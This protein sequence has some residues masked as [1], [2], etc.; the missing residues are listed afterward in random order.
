[1]PENVTVYSGEMARLTCKVTQSGQSGLYWLITEERLLPSNLPDFYQAS[2]YIWSPEGFDD[3]YTTSIALEM[4]GI[5]ET[6]NTSVECIG[7]YS[8]AGYILSDKVYLR[9]QGKNSYKYMYVYI[10]RSWL[11]M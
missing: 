10:S 5:S 7:H 6:D 4:I 3:P 1:M 2:R 8:N 9:V 11:S